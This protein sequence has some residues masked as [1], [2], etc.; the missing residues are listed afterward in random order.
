MSLTSELKDENSPISK[1]FK[2]RE[3]SIVRDIVKNHN[4]LMARQQIIRPTQ[5]TDFGL[6]GKAVSF[7]LQKYFAEIVNVRYWVQ[8]TIAGKAG[9]EMGLIGLAG[10][11]TSKGATPEQEAYKCLLLA[12]AE[13]YGRCR[14][15]HEFIQ[16]F[17]RDGGQNFKPD[18]AFFERWYP[19]IR[20]AAAIIQ[21][22][23]EAWET[24]GFI[25]HGNLFSNATFDCSG[26]VGGADAQII[27]GNTLVD[28]RTTAK[29]RPFGLNNFYQQLAYC[30]M[31]TS[32]RYEIKQLAWFYSR[33]RSVFLYP[34]TSLFK[35]LE[36][37][38]IEFRHMI[39]ENYQKEDND[40]MDRLRGHG[41]F[42]DYKDY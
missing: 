29:R 3:N 15:K 41:F 27:T 9:L 13:D 37:T 7:Y 20:D 31:D 30:L 26:N 17:L 19:T 32:D 21:T 8:E 1:W 10:F 39:D 16:P 18:S 38:R 6:V 2:S 24:V 34:V 42:L 11:V 35:N 4:N 12:A 25:P 40:P 5:G 33:Q 22:V 28:V 36:Q 14:E 23:S